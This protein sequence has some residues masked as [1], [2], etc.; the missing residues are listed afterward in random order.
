MLSK[1]VCQT[2]SMK[3]G[4]RVNLQQGAAELHR[5]Q[6]HLGHW[7]VATRAS[8]I[9]ERAAASVGGWGG[10]PTFNDLCVHHPH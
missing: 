10:W 8:K 1:E 2:G 5:A 3:R 7:D 6:C 4:W 9:A